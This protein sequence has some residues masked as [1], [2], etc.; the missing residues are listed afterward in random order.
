[1]AKRMQSNF[2]IYVKKFSGATLSCMEDY[3][4]PSLR[5][6]PDHFFSYVGTNG[7][8]SEKSSMKIVKSIINLACL[9]KKQIYGVRVSTIILR[10]DD[11]KLIEKRMEVN[12][13]LKELSKENLIGNS[14]KM[15]LHHLSKGKL[16]LTKY[17]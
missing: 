15:K 16:H 11:K 12:L 2:K 14:R 1:M 4:K 10:T 7:L 5:N 6:P 13:H 17:V 9:L 8:S 3:L